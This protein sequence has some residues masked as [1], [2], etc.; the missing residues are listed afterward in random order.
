VKAGAKDAPFSLWAETN[1]DEKDPRMRVSQ[2]MT[3][4]AYIAG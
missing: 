2:A 3:R 4:D 1:R